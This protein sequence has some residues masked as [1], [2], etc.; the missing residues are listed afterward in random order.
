MR[1]DGSNDSLEVASSRSLAAAVLRS[2]SAPYTKAGPSGYAEID[3]VGTVRVS[4]ALGASDQLKLTDGPAPNGA[5]N[6]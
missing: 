6:G 5:C 4:T 1:F 3:V 2:S